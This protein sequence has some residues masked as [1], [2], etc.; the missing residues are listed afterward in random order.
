MSGS[1]SGSNSFA[2]QVATYISQN[3]SGPVASISA[4][5]ATYGSQLAA[6]YISAGLQSLESA[7]GGA[8]S[9]TGTSTLPS[10]S[11]SG[12]GLSSLIQEGISQLAPQ[13]GSSGS[14]SLNALVTAGIQANL[15]TGV[16]LNGSTLSFPS[17]STPFGSF[18][19]SVQNGTLSVTPTPST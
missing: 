8:T 6:S 15:P 3:A 12:I 2:Q 10:A 16:S 7:M 9:P 14:T 13:L 18:S 19:A 4:A 1:T 5:A 17:I 11:T